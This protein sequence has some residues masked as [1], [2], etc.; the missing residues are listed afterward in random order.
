[1]PHSSFIY[2]LEQSLSMTAHTSIGKSLRMRQIK[3][4]YILQI[5]LQKFLLLRIFEEGRS[6]TPVPRVPQLGTEVPS[7]PYLGYFSS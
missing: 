2:P 3:F 6:I 4:D 7:V 1:M 5:T